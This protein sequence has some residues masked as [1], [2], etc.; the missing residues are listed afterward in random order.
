MTDTDECSECHNPDTQTV[1]GLT[2]RQLNRDVKGV[3]QLASLARRGLVTGMPKKLTE[4][5]KLID[6]K[7]ETQPLDQRVRSYLDTNCST[8]HR[9]GGKGSGAMDL[10]VDTPFAKTGLGRRK[11]IVR[12]GLPERSWIWLRMIYENRRKMPNR[13]TMH[14][15]EAGANMIHDWVGSLK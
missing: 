7:D 1:L 11:N 9:P 6:P 2:T 14:T 4:L 10:R 5:P 12:R 15:D 13:L 8:C 3:N